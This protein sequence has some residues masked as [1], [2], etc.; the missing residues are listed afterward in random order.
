MKNEELYPEYINYLNWRLESGKINK[1]KWSLLK[2][3][4]SSFDE[5]LKRMDL[6]PTF[7]EMIFEINRTEQRDKKIDD[8]FNDFN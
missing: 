8:I 1:G 5:F 4:R 6:D 2:M 7:S 3:S